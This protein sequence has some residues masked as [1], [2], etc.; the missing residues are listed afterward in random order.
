MSKIMD[1]LT[2]VVM[3]KVQP[4]LEKMGNNPYIASLQDAYMKAMPLILTGSFSMVFMT[5]QPYLPGWFPNLTNLYYFSLGMLGLFVAYLFPSSV[6]ERKKLK[7]LSKQTGILGLAVFLIFINPVID[8]SGMFTVDILRLG[9]MGSL[10]AIVGGIFVAMVMSFFAKHPI[11]KKDSPM[12]SFIQD[13]FNSLFPCFVCIFIA[14]NVCFSLGIDF[15]SVLNYICSPLLDAAQSYWGFILIY[16]IGFTFVYAFGI[17]PWVISSITNVAAYIG[18]A[19]N[20]ALY[21]QGLAPNMINS[22]EV[23]LWVILGGS[24]A[25]LALSCQ[26]LFAKSKK[27]KAVGKTCIVPSIMNINEPLVYGMPIAMNPIMMIPFLACG[28]IMPAIVYPVFA[29]GLV[30]IPGRISPFGFFFPFDTWYMSGIRGMIFA[31]ILIAIAW[32]IYYPFFKAYDNK[33]LAEESAEK[34]QESV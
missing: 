5:L 2:D 11:I 28:L 25:T 14:Y 18:S 9:G 30:P 16:F 20:Y 12:P 33:L 13:W 26:L 34:V 8:E 3:G 6:M 31:F 19:N 29:S 1:K 4:L 21:G 24:G 22:N 17:S 23:M 27:L 7:R 32:V 15:Y 10:S